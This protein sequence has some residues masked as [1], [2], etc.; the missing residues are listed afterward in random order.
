MNLSRSSQISGGQFLL[1]VEAVDRVMS[2]AFP[3]DAVLH[4]FFREHPQMGMQDR[5]FVAEGTYALLRRIEWLRTLTP[6]SACRRLVLAMLS[7]VQGR[8]TR[9]LKAFCQGN[10]AEWLESLRA[11]APPQNLAIQADLPQWVVDRLIRHETPEEIL[12]LGRAMQEPAALDLRV[13]SLLASRE[14]VLASLHEAGLE[15]DPT[16]WSPMGVRV[17]GRPMLQR[18]PVFES[19]KVE[20]QD[21]GSQLLGLLVAP[22][23]RQMVVDF[24]AGA[25]GKTLLLGALMQNQ[26]RV[27]A[28]DVS[29]KRLDQLKPRLK[30]SGLSNLHPVL[31]SGEKDPRVQ[32]LAGKVDR[33][34]VD[35]P[36][37][38][39]GTLRRNPDLK[40]RQ[41]EAGLEDLL[42]KQ[43]RILEAAARLLK[44]GGRLVYATCSL[45]PDENE[46]QAEAFSHAHPELEPVHCQE[47]LAALKIELDTGKYLRLRPH[48]HGTDGFFAALWERRN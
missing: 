40:L 6:T 12:A 1:L 19:G 28:F 39:L 36:C 43:R 16:P 34:L 33:V 26:G 21:E 3:A 46:E 48:R 29:R 22:R 7:R 32:R 10:E 13:N 23:R 9:E 37:T 20:V 27:Y 41:S 44:P 8:S 24:C 15:A 2:S 45:L 42:M 31:I 14:E 18:L 35:A 38:G 17:T 25:G 4:R 30:R 47:A 11:V 5:S